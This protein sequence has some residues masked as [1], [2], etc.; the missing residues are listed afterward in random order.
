MYKRQVQ[1]LLRAGDL[2]VTQAQH[3]RRISNERTQIEL[4]RAAVEELSLIHI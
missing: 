1:Q 3:L 4:A 2:S